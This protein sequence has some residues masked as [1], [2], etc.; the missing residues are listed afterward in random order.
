MKKAIAILLTLIL[1]LSVVSVSA[2]ASDG[3][4][5]ILDFSKIDFNAMT[6]M[7]KDLIAVIKAAV[8]F[9]QNGMPGLPFGG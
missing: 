8:A 3:E 2:F 6:N 7:I 9:V 5:F 1:L 4:T